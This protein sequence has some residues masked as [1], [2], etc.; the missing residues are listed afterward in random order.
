LHAAAVLTIGNLYGHGFDRARLSRLESLGFTLRPEVSTYAGSQLC[1]FIDF[2]EGPSLELIEVTDPADYEAF[3]P[4]GMEPYC[5]GISLV[6]DDGSPAALDDCEREFADHEPYRLR[7]AYRDGDGPDA[8]GWHY[9]NFG[10]PMVPGTF[11]WLTA[12]DQP[13]PTTARNTTHANGVRGVV[14]LVFELGADELRDLSRLAGRSLVGHTLAIGGVEVLT[15]DVSTAPRL[16]PLRAVVLRAARLDA[17]RRYAPSAEA[18][19]V[20]GRPAV[21]IET[22]P[23]AWDLLVTT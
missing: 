5:P 19:V 2:A 21:R 13:R 6:V 9:L 4:A 11:A 20:M 16:F 14:G 12:F 18:T 23:T 3:V 10:R 1:S 8:P 22:S 15:T 7:V 17:F